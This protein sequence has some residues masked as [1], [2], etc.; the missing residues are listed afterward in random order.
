MPQAID[1]LW[2]AMGLMIS[3]W[4][5]RLG[6]RCCWWPIR[7]ANAER[8]FAE[9]RNIASDIAAVSRNSGIPFGYSMGFCGKPQGVVLA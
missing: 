2:A 6:L 5:V 3:H 1:V 7:R 9:L 8:D 4:K